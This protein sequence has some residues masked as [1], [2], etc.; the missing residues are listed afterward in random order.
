MLSHIIESLWPGSNL[1]EGQFIDSYS[2]MSCLLALLEQL[3]QQQSTNAETLWDDLK[4]LL[5]V[6]GY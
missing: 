3:G 4:H 5:K 6:Q 2:K 1:H